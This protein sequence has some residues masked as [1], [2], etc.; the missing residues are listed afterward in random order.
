VR[1]L[2]R[3]LEDEVAQFERLFPGRIQLP[4]TPSPSLKLIP[5]WNGEFIFKHLV[6]ALIFDGLQNA[7]PSAKVSLRLRRDRDMLRLSVE[8]VGQC[9]EDEFL[10]RIRHPKRVKYLLDSL[11]GRLEAAPNGI[12]IRVPVMTCASIETIIEEVP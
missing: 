4:S 12:L 8:G 5:S 3:A 11:G 9:N 6:R 2:A 10:A 1:C 7:G